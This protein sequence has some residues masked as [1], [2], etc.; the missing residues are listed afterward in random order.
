MFLLVHQPVLAQ[1][2]CESEGIEVGFFNGVDTT[3]TQAETALA[4]M[5][6]LYPSTTPKGQPIN[7]T[8][9]YNDTE[10]FSDFMETFEQR[11][12]E[13]AGLLGG[14]FELFFEAT[15]GGGSWWD[16]LTRAIPA[17][18]DVLTG[19]GNTFLASVVRGLTERFLAPPATY[20]TVSQRHR[21]QIDHAVG[22]GR[23]MLLF[24]HSQGNLFVNAAYDHALARSDSDSV[25]VV[26]VAP[27]S[28]RLTGG[29]T[30]AD[31]DVVING[32]FAAGLVPPST[33]QIPG[34]LL[35]PPGLSGKK[36]FLGHG[37]LE[38][39]L[40][41]A[42]TTA[43]RIRSQVDAALRALDSAP[44]KQMPP[45]PDFVETPW[46]GGIEPQ[47]AWTPSTTSHVLEKVV[48]RFGG[49]STVWEWREGLVPTSWG[50]V[51]MAGWRPVSNG[52][53]TGT[54]EFSIEQIGKGLGGKKVCRIQ[55]M[56]PLPGEDPYRVTVCSFQRFLLGNTLADPV[57][58][59]LRALG[60]AR[61]GASVSLPQETYDLVGVP[62]QRRGDSLRVGFFTGSY[63]SS[64]GIESRGTTSW[65]PFIVQPGELFNEAAQK[66]WRISRQAFEAAE[67]RRYGLYREARDAYER[68][69]Q[70]CEA[71]S[72]PAP[73]PAPP[74]IPSPFLAQD[75][76]I[77]HDLGGCVAA[78]FDRGSPGRSSDGPG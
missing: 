9:Y 30:L 22:Q 77:P 31:L 69:R 5:R 12:M 46:T 61:P 54:S 10:G 70:A 38:I 68:R 8:L 64:V 73:P 44:K 13:H 58:Q 40:N 43:G 45:Y 47:L 72:I 2:T 63:D 1:E 26:H 75:R 35:R 74:V 29:H 76:C 16:A 19:L 48:Y 53:P 11:L 7:Y 51:T 59:E 62:L 37:L 15:R 23:K 60:A 28:P 42:L 52:L 4:W 3:K 55:Q 78:L 71:A 67:L 66:N 33:D 18:R 27:A 57:P 65:E 36:D 20:A 17:T 39:Y 24:A 50:S 21:D 14:R 6:K 49:R 56:E 41:P 34:Y 25:R 32:L